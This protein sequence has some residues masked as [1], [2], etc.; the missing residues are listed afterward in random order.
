LNRL[1]RLVHRAPYPPPAPERDVVYAIG[2][3][4]GR[5]DLLERLIGDILVDAGA[6]EVPAQVVLLGDYIDRTEHVAEAMDFLIAVSDWREL[7][8]V[9]LIGNHEQ[10][11]LEFL[12]DPTRGEAWLNFGGLQTLASYGLRVRSRTGTRTDYERI[13]G[14]LGEAMGEHIEFLDAA[15]LFHLSGNLLFC[16]AGADPA[17]PA[18]A[19]KPR[20]LLWGHPDFGKVQRRD[21]I[22]VVHGHTVVEAPVAERGIVSIDTGAYFSG[23]LTAARITPGAVS[24]LQS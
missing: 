2:D 4:H 14:E 15:Q 23:T 21:G 1:R 3:I 5:V 20:D 12:A 17:V 22:W 11:L 19:Q 7:E 10:M 16:H 6:Y 8:L 24:F 9:P 18:A 13:R